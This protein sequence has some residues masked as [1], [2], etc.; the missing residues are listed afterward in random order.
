MVGRRRE[1]ELDID[2]S[3]LSLHWT[4]WICIMS[5]VNRVRIRHLDMLRDVIL[6]FFFFNY[7]EMYMT[8]KYIRDFGVARPVATAPEQCCDI[9]VPLEISVHYIIW[10]DMY[11]CGSVNV[12]RYVIQ[13]RVGRT[14]N[15]R[16]P[17]RANDD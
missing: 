10:V 3:R 6:V 4:I 9:P 12:Y 8:G 15:A 2:L 5:N 11:R 1:P 13:A 7:Y 16:E 17:L 14:R